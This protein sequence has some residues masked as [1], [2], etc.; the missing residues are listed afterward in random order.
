MMMMMMMI[1]QSSVW[2]YWSRVRRPNLKPPSH[3]SVWLIGWMLC[4]HAG[5]KQL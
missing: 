5:W 4:C 1:M 2:C 3:C